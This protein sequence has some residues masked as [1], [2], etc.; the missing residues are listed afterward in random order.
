MG[1]C[2]TVTLINRLKFWGHSHNA[3]V[4]GS[5][6]PIA[7]TL[8]IQNKRLTLSRLRSHAGATGERGAFAGLSAANS[9]SQ[10]AKAVAILVPSSAS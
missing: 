4:G 10:Q 8:L 9:I 1:A 2:E 5:I 3:E 6:L 7:T